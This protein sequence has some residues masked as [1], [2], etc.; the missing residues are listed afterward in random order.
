MTVRAAEPVATWLL[1]LLLLPNEKTS[2]NAV[3][4]LIPI[5]LG[6]GLSAVAPGSNMT[7]SGFCLVMLCNVCFS[8]RTIVTKLLKSWNQD[9]D[10]YSLFLQLCILGSVW[11]G[12]I[13]VTTGVESLKQIVNI[14]ILLVNGLTFYL[15]LQLSWVVMSRV[16]AVTHSVCNSLRRPVICAAGWFVF[17]GMTSEG[18]AGALIATAGTLLYAREKRRT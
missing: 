14:P 11:Q 6:A 10:N 2:M 16:G 7:T 13:L 8:L 5:V 15:Y 1:G 3:F 12:I 17:G 18:V 9:V 4:C